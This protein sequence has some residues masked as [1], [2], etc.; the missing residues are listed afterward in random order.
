MKK[1]ASNKG[2]ITIKSLATISSLVALSNIANPILAMAKTDTK[3][4]TGN[5]KTKA[6]Y[7]D[8]HEYQRKSVSDNYGQVSIAQKLESIIEDARGTCS[9]S[10]RCTMALAANNFLDTE[11]RYA[12]LGL[13]TVSMGTYAIAISGDTNKARMLAIVENK[14]DTTY[15]YDTIKRFIT[16]KQ[17]EMK[18]MGLTNEAEIA[19]K[20]IIKN[21]GNFT[22]VAMNPH[23]EESMKV[24]EDG[25]S[26]LHQ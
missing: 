8:R 2:N 7:I 16:T 13:K 12:E 9:G 18:R 20:A 19:S 15:N 23:E 14:Y 6:V 1:R 25:L 3:A 4:E 11:T 24:I 22:V 17:N 21:I 26:Y 5:T 10:A